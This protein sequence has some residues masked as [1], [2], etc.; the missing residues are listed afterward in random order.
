MPLTISQFAKLLDLSPSTISK[1][2]NGYSDISDE[3]RERVLIAIKEFGYQPIA[4]ARSLRL[5]KSNR[6]G[7]V[8][9]TSTLANDFFIRILKGCTI[10]AEELGYNLV[11]YTAAVDQP[12][13]ILRACISKDIDGLLIM[14]SGKVET[15]LDQ[16]SQTGIPFMLVGRETRIEN[17]PFIS[18]DNEDGVYQAISHLTAQGKKEIAFIGQKDDPITHESRFRGYVRAMQE[19]QL[20]IRE[21]WIVSA[22]SSYPGGYYA[23]QEI[24]R[25]SNRPE[26]IFC[27]SDG[28]AIESLPA[29]SEFG[30]RVP[31]D[32]ALVSCDNIPMSQSTQPPL[33]TINIPLEE[34]GKLA[35]RNLIDKIADPLFELPRQILPVDLIIRE[36]SKKI[37]Q[38]TRKEK[39]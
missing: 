22:S 12:D 37:C 35:T 24:L 3:T 9:P 18:P 14:G 27:F 8:N 1:A 7:V 13:L 11:L 26:A 20:S 2:I 19:Q 33:T 31:Q 36:S 29:F 4:S 32:I 17:V 30:I 15:I 21:E 34:I 39:H 16:I 5:R 28:V 10:Q 38:E 6:I 25:Q 23:M